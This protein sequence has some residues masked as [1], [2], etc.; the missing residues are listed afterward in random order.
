MILKTEKNFGKIVGVKAA[1]VYIGKAG[2]RSASQRS[3]SSFEIHIIRRDD[4]SCNSIFLIFEHLASVFFILAG[5]DDLLTDSIVIHQSVIDD[6]FIVS[7]WHS[8]AFQAQLIY[9]VCDRMHHQNSVCFAIDAVE[10]VGTDGTLCAADVRLLC[11]SFHVFF[12]ESQ[13]GYDFIIEEI[14]VSQIFVGCLYHGFSGHFDARK[15]TDA[16]SYDG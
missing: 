4:D 13:R 12:F 11:E 15:E 10:D 7:L 8:A 14:V 16:Q 2:D 9:P 5:N 6:T 3:R 1:S